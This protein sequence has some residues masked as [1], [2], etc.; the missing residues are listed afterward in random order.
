VFLNDRATIGLTV[1]A[2][3]PFGQFCLNPAQD[4]N[5]VL[6]GAGSGITPLTAM[7]RYIDD[8]CL[9]THTTLLYCVR[10]AKDI[11]FRAEL[12]ELE[13]RL[14]NFRCH[15]ALS[16]PDAEWKGA[17]GRISREFL[18]QAVPDVK[19]RV[20]FLCGPLPF[21][22]AARTMLTELGVEAEQIRQEI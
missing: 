4:R 11:I 14:R 19:G 21:M 12:E 5:I 13:G 18:L 3:G 20:F 10:S 22:E 8:L 1:E 15:I 16:Q 9:D 7:L 2:S 17:R 6:I